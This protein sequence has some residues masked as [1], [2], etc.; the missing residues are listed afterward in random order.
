M[1]EE[2][3][4]ELDILY[5]CYKELWILFSLLQHVCL[6]AKRLA[7]ELLTIANTKEFRFCVFSM[8]LSKPF[9]SFH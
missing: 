3:G 4:R 6:A 8:E 9:S 2:L 5:L 1:L 7:D